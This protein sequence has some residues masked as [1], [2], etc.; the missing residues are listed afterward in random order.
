M[1]LTETL[2]TEGEEFDDFVGSI[3][4]LMNKNIGIE[5][6]YTKLENKYK[7]LKKKIQKTG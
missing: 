5:T 7:K 2:I 4:E 1:E 3:S 6:D